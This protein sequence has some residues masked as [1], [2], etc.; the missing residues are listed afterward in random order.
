MMT[1][2]IS[3]FL[4][5]IKNGYL[6]RK[7]NLIIPYSKIKEELANLLVKE[8]YLGKVEIQKAEKLK[9]NI[10]IS[11][12]YKGKQPK[13][14]DV[15]R[16]SK[17]SR[18]VYVSKEEIPQVL[19]GLGITIISTPLGLMTGQEARKRGVGGEIVCKIW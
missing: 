2:P 9:K 12:V 10:Q 13:L 17:I 8:G 16:V 15:V 7:A 3:D 1:D 14:T 6:A 5:Q 18:R 11:L 4:I 19:G